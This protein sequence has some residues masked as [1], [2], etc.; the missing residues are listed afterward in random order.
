MSVEVA[1][2]LAG[3]WYDAA[4]A[5][6]SRAEDPASRGALELAALARRVLD[7][8]AED[9]ATM[10]ATFDRPWAQRLASAS[11][12]RDPRDPARGAL[13]SLVG[14]YE[15]MLEALDVRAARREPLFVVVSAHIIGEYLRQ[16]VWESTLGHAGDPLVLGEYVGEKWGTDDKTCSH[17]ALF[18]SVA[19]RSLN[20][21]SGDV[22]GYDAYLEKFHSRLGDALAVCA[23]NHRTT[24]PG[25]RP[26]TGQTCAKPCGW[27]LR[28][29]LDDRADLDARCRLALLYVETPIV[30]LRHQAPVGHFFGVPSMAEIEDAWAASWEKLSA[31]WKDG[32]NP[33]TRKRVPGAPGPA[34]ALPGMSE[35]VSVVAGRTIGPGT[36][37]RD[38]AADAIALLDPKGEARPE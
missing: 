2:L 1:E 21:C 37:I 23:M 24:A 4:E 12:P 19:K 36:V 11:F 38:I 20:A 17:N 6:L 25:Q 14:L 13:G 31:P 26:D 7:L 28:G 8:D 9:F 15:L 29:T 22:A 34:E 35:L 3:G 5:V 27:A 33:L 18:R 32:C 30:A 16:L 10:A